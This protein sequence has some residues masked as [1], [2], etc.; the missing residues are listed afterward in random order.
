[1]LDDEI[2]SVSELLRWHL[3]ILELGSEN[4]PIDLLKMNV[5][6]PSLAV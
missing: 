4:Y 6:N 5:I 1:M 2:K 3:E